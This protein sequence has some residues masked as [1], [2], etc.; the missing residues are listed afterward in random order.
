MPATYI[1]VLILISLYLQLQLQLTTY[2]YCHLTSNLGG[3]VVDLNTIF[4][5]RTYERVNVCGH[6]D[7]GD[8]DPLHTL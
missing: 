7:G 6:N 5:R 2:K 3:L 1:G 4:Q 8:Q